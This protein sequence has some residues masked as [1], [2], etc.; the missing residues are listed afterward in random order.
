MRGQSKS[1]PCFHSQE[2]STIT[3]VME[4]IFKVNVKEDVEDMDLCDFTQDTSKTSAPPKNHRL[5]T[6]A[7]LNTPPEVHSSTPSSK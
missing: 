4:E 7:I 5:V 2:L 1:F 6:P 3:E